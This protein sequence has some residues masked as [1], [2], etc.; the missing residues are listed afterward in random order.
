M[1]RAAQYDNDAPTDLQYAFMENETNRIAAELDW[2]PQQ[3]QAAIWVA[4]KARMENAGVKKRV[5][6]SSEK[7][8]WI[9]FVKK[10]GGG[11]PVRDVLDAQKHRDNW[12]DH[13]FKHTPTAA[14]TEAAKF[15]FEDGVRRHIGQVS[16]EARPGR[17]TACGPRLRRLD[18]RIQNAPVRVPPLVAVLRPRTRALALGFS[19]PGSPTGADRTGGCVAGPRVSPPP[20]P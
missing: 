2:E 1:M 8:G 17:S 14:D 20:A 16:W 9:R 15:D 10:A 3:V 7:K 19:L 5:E 18:L 13:A 11:A 6:A 4:M 12:L